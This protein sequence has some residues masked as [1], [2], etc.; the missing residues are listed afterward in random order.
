MDQTEVLQ[1]SI[2]TILEI[3]TNKICSTVPF[4]IVILLF[5]RQNAKDYAKGS[6]IRLIAWIQLRFYKNQILLML[7]NID[8]ICWNT[9]SFDYSISDVMSCKACF[10][11]FAIANLTLSSIKTR[12]TYWYVVSRGC[13]CVCDAIWSILRKDNRISHLQTH[14]WQCMKRYIIGT[15]LSLFLFFRI[16]KRFN[17]SI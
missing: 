6:Q 17:A 9:K 11:V 16:L 2:K 15:K 8:S 5:W 14:E 3:R 4:V 10:H 1:T 7:L 13:C 12:K